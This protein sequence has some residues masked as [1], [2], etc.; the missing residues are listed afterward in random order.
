MWSF[1][2]ITKQLVIDS[3]NKIID[4]GDRYIEYPALILLDENI[5]VSRIMFEFYYSLSLERHVKR[6]PLD[7]NFI[8]VDKCQII[9]GQQTSDNEYCVQ[10]KNSKAGTSNVWQA[11][12][13]TYPKEQI[14]NFF[15]LTE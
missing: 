2:Q 13:R 7:Q 15:R 11:S 9:T 6:L 1:P 10:F 4:F 5:E 3:S 12:N 8:W 14:Q